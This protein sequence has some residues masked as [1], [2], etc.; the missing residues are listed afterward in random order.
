MEEYGWVSNT[1][2]QNT[3]GTFEAKER[4][5]TQGKACTNGWLWLKRGR[6]EVGNSRWVCLSIRTSIL[7]ILLRHRE[8]PPS[9][10]PLSHPG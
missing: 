5:K 2:A 1:S 6:E 3:L 7:Q 9:M 8:V 10:K 4:R